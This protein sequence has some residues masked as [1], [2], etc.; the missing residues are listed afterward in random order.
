MPLHS[1]LPSALVTI[2]RSVTVAAGRFAP[3]HLGELTAVVSFELVDA[4]LEETRTV[5]RRLRE[6]PSRVGIYFLL[7][8]CLFSEVGYRLRWDKLTA[9]LTRDALSP[10]RPR[11]RCAICAEG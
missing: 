7:V 3:G 5:Q 9:S 1:P 10:L 4:V 2:T 6:L 11:K 8:M